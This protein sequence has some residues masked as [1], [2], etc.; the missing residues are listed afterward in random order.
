VEQ[1]QKEQYVPALV[2]VGRLAKS[3]IKQKEGYC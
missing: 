2:Q 1:G 3:R